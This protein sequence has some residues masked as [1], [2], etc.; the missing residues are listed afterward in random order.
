[1]Y[2]PHYSG[3]GKIGDPHPPHLHYK[4]MEITSQF[5][6][7]SAFFSNSGAEAVENAIKICYDHKKTTGTGSASTALS[8]AAPWALFP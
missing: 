5:G 3:S 8:T 7:G 1:M 4:L 2:V 6:F